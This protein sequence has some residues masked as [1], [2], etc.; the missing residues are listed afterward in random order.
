MT[1]YDC[2][3]LGI[4][5]GP[6]NMAMAVA[7]DALE[8]NEEG[9]VLRLCFIE[10]NE[11][12][13]WHPGM[14]LDQ[15]D[16]QV[17]FLKDMA[18]SVD[19][20]SPYTF[21]N[22]MKKTD[23]LNDFINLRT[24]YPPRMEYRNY[25]RWVADQF[26]HLVRYNSEVVNIDALTKNTEIDGF[27]IRYRDRVTGAENTM[28]ARNIILAC[29]A[30][31]KLPRDCKASFSERV[32]HSSAF[33][34]NLETTYPE[35][36]RDYR[37]L[38]IGSG[39]SSAEMF[40]HLYTNYPNAK[41]RLVTPNIGF[42]PAD[43]S[44]FVNKL[45]YNSFIDEYYTAAPSFREDFVRKHKDSNYSAVDVGLIAGVAADMYADRRFQSNRLSHT[46]FARVR[47]IKESDGVE[48]VL[49][50]DLTGETDTHHCD[51][52][53]LGTGY[54]FDSGLDLIEGI[55]EHIIWDDNDQPVLNRDYSIKARDM[56]A[57]I[58]LLGPTEHTHGLA[59]T[60]L[61]LMPQR[62]QEIMASIIENIDQP[63]TGSVQRQVKVG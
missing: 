33:L 58:Y 10:K 31:P 37:F 41:V 35:Q 23:G 2:D 14:L 36:T 24:F 40:N 51:A 28:T 1:Q 25:L 19:P 63:Q 46:R 6:S 26:D 12:F 48:V 30:M 45:F 27:S 8:K 50:N 53:F 17:S 42:K 59:S 7:H 13:D 57:K 56:S 16:M 39:Q 54:R 11:I 4:G 62:A 18:T 61:S 21:L 29:G 34:N 22:Y 55:H 47:E 32:I 60:L 44:E 38:V 43:D 49:E 3:A 9:T 5:F 52:V 15:A 20:T